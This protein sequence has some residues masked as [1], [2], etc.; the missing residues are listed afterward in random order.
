MVRS[1][2]FEEDTLLF[3]TAL[4]KTQKGLVGFINLLADI[5]VPIIPGLQRLSN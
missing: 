2:Y 5:F 3:L 4:K 1:D